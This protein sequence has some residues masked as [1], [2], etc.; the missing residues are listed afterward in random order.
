MTDS[1][2]NRFPVDRKLLARLF[3]KIKISNELFHNGTPCWEWLGQL[4]NKGYGL[5]SY[6]GA[7]G[8]KRAA[9]RIVYQCFVE[10]INKPLECD[11]LCRN[12][13]CVSPI[14]I[15]LV[16]HAENL[17]RSNFGATLNAKKTHCKYGHE[18][19]PDNVKRNRDG[20]RQCRICLRNRS[21]ASGTKRR[22]RLKAL[23]YDH[24]ERVAD[25]QKSYAAR[26]R[27]AAKQKL[28]LSI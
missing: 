16:T 15:E 9:H 23:P 3:S 19:T 12:T 24:P 2:S 5:I 11:H 22:D 14:H 6:G 1:D 21:R 20:W 8:G 10:I 13:A 18:F 27:W 25:R 17:W 7:Q 26:A 4:N 28:K